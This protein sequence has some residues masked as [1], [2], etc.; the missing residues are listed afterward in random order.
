MI[1]IRIIRSN[2]SYDF[3]KTS[4]LNNFSNNVKNTYLDEFQLLSDADVIL[5][6]KCQS[7]SNH[8]TSNVNESIAP[9]EFQIKLFAEKRAYVNPVHVIMHAEDLEGEK[10]G[11]DYGDGMQMDKESGLSGRWLVHDDWN[12]VTSRPYY[13]PYSAGCI[14]LPAHQHIILN[15]RLAELGLKSGDVLEAVLEVKE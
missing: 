14:I 1:N 10:I 8:P 6:C 2:K 11:E 3:K 15:T 9:G 13:Y 5:K 7:V 4:T 12:P